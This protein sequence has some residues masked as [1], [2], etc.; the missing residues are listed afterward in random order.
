MWRGVKDSSE[1]P[2]LHAPGPVGLLPQAGLAGGGVD[3]GA[4]GAGG[5]QGEGT[6]GEGERR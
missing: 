6:E 1:S 4:E 3:R 2:Y 5:Q